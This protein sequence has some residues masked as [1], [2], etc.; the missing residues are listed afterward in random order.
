MEMTNVKRKLNA[1][2]AI[3][4]CT[5][6]FAGY[7]VLAETE[8]GWENVDGT[9]YYR[10][11]G[12]LL[13][14]NL[15]NIGDYCYSFDEQGRMITG[16]HKT[17][18]G[19]V[20]HTSYGNA[21]ENQWRKINNNWYYFTTPYAVQ[22]GIWVIDGQAYCF[23][24]NGIMIKGWKKIDGSW[25]YF[26]QDGSMAQNQWVKSEGKWYFFNYF[27]QMYSSSWVFD[28]GRQYYM[29]R[30]GSMATGTLIMDGVEYIF[31]KDGSLKSAKGYVDPNN[32]LTKS[33]Y[34]AKVQ[35]FI[36]TPA[37]ANG[38]VWDWNT[39]SKLT[40]FPIGACDGYAYEFIKYVFNYDLTTLKQ[41][42]ATAD[43]QPYTSSE[44]S[45][46]S[47]IRAGDMLGLNFTTYGQDCGHVIVVLQRNGNQ[48]LTAEGNMDGRVVI[49][50]SW[51]YISNNTLQRRASTNMRI[52][53]GAHF[54]HQ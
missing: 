42:N 49:S 48:L 41:T 36:S 47:S 15:W 8:N 2:A 22:D 29:H 13:K 46:A 19:I 35:A 43:Y 20:Y 7:P 21:V 3:L 9:W 18:N 28:N 45:N 11:N 25:Y 5:G 40:A 4:L 38:A 26:R 50:N 1:V 34:D 37:Y 31:N 54:L 51:Y 6:L 39:M 32:Y 10:E 12:E 44:L 16:L 24:E 27:G 33:E 30:D 52:T 23:D 14:G 17:E 53:S